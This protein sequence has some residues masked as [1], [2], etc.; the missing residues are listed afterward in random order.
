[1]AKYLKG[2]LAKHIGPE[3]DIL[4][5][6]LKSARGNLVRLGLKDRR[7]ILAALVSEKTLSSIGGIVLA[8]P[9]RAIRFDNTFEARLER[10]RPQLRKEVAGLLSG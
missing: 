1:M 5:R 9:D 6:I 8:T 2:W 10:L 7:E 3:A 4:V